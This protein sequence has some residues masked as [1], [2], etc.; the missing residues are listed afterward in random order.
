MEMDQDGVG[1]CIELFSDGHG[2]AVIGDI[3]DVE[4]FMAAFEL[5]PRDEEGR[6]LARALCWG[7]SAADV[8]AM[9]PSNR[10]DGSR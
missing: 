6:D 4:R 7:S 5:V 8:A 9:S 2:L 10:G 1:D 3:A